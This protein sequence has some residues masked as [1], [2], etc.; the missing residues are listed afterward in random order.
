MRITEERATLPAFKSEHPLLTERL[1]FPEKVFRENLALAHF[2]GARTKVV[3]P[4]E[5]LQRL[6]LLRH[7]TGVDELVTTATGDILL[8]I[9]H[10]KLQ[11][12][13]DLVAMKCVIKFLMALL[14]ATT[15]DEDIPVM[16]YMTEQSRP[17]LEIA[18]TP[19]PLLA[20]AVNLPR[21][22]TLYPADQLLFHLCSI[23]VVR[24]G[25]SLLIYHLTVDQ[26]SMVLIETPI[27][28]DL[29]RKKLVNLR[30]LNYG[31]IPGK[32]ER[33]GGLQGCLWYPRYRT[34]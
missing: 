5:R 1:W 14:L 15:Q 23:L 4:P 11:S 9:E 2:K 28:A 12:R 6:K 10:A 33:W 17:C 8:M 29:E 3:I 32:G 27:F 18:A 30:K 20:L 31:R 24:H 34:L 16:N 25:G 13:Q 26:K 19:H 21:S 7:A 22:F